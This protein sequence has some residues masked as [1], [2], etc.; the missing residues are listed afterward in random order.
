M[1]PNSCGLAGLDVQTRPALL[2]L[3]YELH[4]AR[5]P[6]IILGLR[7]QDALPEWITHVALVD[8]GRI[9]TGTKGDIERLVRESSNLSEQ[10]RV[11]SVPKVATDNGG[12]VLVDMNNV[13]V[14]YGD[15]TVR[16]L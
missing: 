13:S 3:L 16:L 15:R 7:T 4:S 9:H 6:R 12:E 5:R 11:Y 1:R 14:N 2:S 10:S 8:S